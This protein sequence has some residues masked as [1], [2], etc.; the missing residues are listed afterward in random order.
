MKVHISFKLSEQFKG[1]LRKKD[2]A[3]FNEAWPSTSIKATSER[4]HN[5]FRAGYRAHSLGHMGFGL[6]ITSA[7]QKNVKQQRRGK[8]QLVG[9]VLAKL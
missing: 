7:Q 3:K 8:M 5:N 6:R 9:H 4:F 1:E 2:R